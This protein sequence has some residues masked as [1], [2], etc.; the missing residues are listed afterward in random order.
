[1]SCPTWDA[2]AVL[3][4]GNWCSAGADGIQTY[5]LPSLYCQTGPQSVR[6]LGSIFCHFLD[7]PGSVHGCRRLLPVS[8]GRWAKNNFIVIITAHAFLNSSLISAVLLNFYF[9]GNVRQILRV[10]AHAASQSLFYSYSLGMPRF[11]EGTESAFWQ[12]ML[13]PNASTSLDQISTLALVTHVDELSSLKQQPAWGLW[14]LQS[15]YQV[16]E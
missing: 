9:S 12:E 7:P 13:V 15:S 10:K 11:L 3:T 14:R 5:W 8:N 16:L 6:V 1:M 4:D 2:K